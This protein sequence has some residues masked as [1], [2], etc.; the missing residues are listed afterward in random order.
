M[1]D[2][3]TDE[4]DEDDDTDDD[5]DD[6]RH[7]TRDRGQRMGTL[8]QCQRIIDMLAIWMEAAAAAIEVKNDQGEEGGKRNPNHGGANPIP[9]EKKKNSGSRSDTLCA[10]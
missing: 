4:D 7:K 6:D 10:V 3:D 1:R 9:I 8:L 5:D 2:D